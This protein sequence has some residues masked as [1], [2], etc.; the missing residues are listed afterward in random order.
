MTWRIGVD[1]GGTFTDVAMIEEATGRIGI[2][3]TPTTPDDFGRG[4]L[5]GLNEALA[6]YGLPAA[7]VTLLSHATTVVTNALLENKGARIALVTTRGF[8]DVLELRRSARADLYDL[9]Q[10]PPAVLVPRHRRL[11]VTERIGAG[12]EVVVPLAEGELPALVAQLQAL[13]V[14][15]VAVSLLFAFQNDA[16]EKALGAAL[17]A[18]LPGVPVFLSCEVLPEIREFERT[19][20]TAVCAYVGPILE[21]YLRRLQQ[22]T[23]SLGLPDLM[24]MGSAG[25]VLDV[26]AALAMPAAAVESGPAAGVIAAQMIGQ[27]LGRPNL[28]S[29]DMGGTTAKASLIENGRVETTAEYEVGSSA[30]QSRWLHGTGHPIRVPVIDLA[31]VSAGGGSIAWIDPAGALRVGPHSAGAAPGPVCYGQ[32]GTEPTITDTNLVLGY[33]D[34][35]SLLGGGLPIDYAAAEAALRERIAQPLG[36]SVE[37]AAAGIRAIVNNAMA[38][39]LRMVSVERGHDPREFAMVAFGGAGPLHACALADE[40]DVPEVIVP[41]I[42]GAF[43][44]LGLVGADIR[45][46]YARTIYA[47]LETLT[48]EHLTAIWDD[49][50]A[51]G[52]A[53]LEA[54][55]VPAGRQELQR[56]ADLRY[57]RQAYELTVDAPAGAVTPAT[58]AGLAD[59]FHAAHERTYGHKNEAEPVHVVTLRL[60]AVGKLGQPRFAEATG[61]GSSLKAERPAWFEA[62]GRVPAPVHDRARLAVGQILEGP[63]IV[64]SLDS[65]L[66]LPPGWR[67]RVDDAGFLRLTRG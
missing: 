64:E 26:P 15:A 24:V 60:S 23:G 44:A 61:D 27:Q 19:S 39:A 2:A 8:R 33:L 21:S 12:G 22:A 3:K 11:E 66:V 35:T 25:G 54:A 40:L 41:P 18:A 14:E 7:D 20:T 58:L 46:D 48:P 30:S 50:A 28:L 36:Q 6:K 47:P 55:R 17:R 38:E 31:E 57:G 52:R 53:M 9:F 32:G 42:P 43:S 4:V 67:A 29:F 62:T 37:Q 63:A 56:Q 45:R 51:E 10:D 16:H 34:A 1:I 59:G 13:D 5:N 49:M 65:T